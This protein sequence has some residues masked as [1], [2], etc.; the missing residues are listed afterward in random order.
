MD[1]VIKSMCG[2]GGC[3]KQKWGIYD[4]NRGALEESVELSN[5]GQKQ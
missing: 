2:G 4:R 5:E 1:I 3:L